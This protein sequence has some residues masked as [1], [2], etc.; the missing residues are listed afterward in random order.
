MDQNI[1]YLG[2]EKDINKKR[3]ASEIEQ[4][5]QD[6]DQVDVDDQQNEKPETINNNEIVSVE[7]NSKKQKN[8]QQKAQREIG[9]CNKL[10]KNQKTKSISN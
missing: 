2:P 8:K 4:L 5:P 10:S 6:Q 1:S 9:I 3:K 7:K